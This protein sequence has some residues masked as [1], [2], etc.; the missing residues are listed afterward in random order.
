MKTSSY[1]VE[2]GAQ[3]FAVGEK[4]TL[5]YDLELKKILKRN[6]KLILDYLE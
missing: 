1:Q 3:K 6:L 2:I 4:I 5:Q